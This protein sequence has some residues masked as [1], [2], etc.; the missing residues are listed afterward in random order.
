MITYILTN[1]IL[2]ILTI[3]DSLLSNVPYYDQ[4][5]AGVYSLTHSIDLLAQALHE[6]A[7]I[8]FALVSTYVVFFFYAWLAYFIIATVKRFIPMS[9]VR[10]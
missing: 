5:S 3:F 7:P 4:V 1:F 9:N 8:S 6:L 10:H 2:S